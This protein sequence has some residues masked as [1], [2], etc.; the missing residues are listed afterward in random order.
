MATKKRVAIAPGRAKLVGT[1]GFVGTP[2]GVQVLKEKPGTVTWLDKAKGYYKEAI[3]VV[4][5]LVVLLN[6]LTPLF[7][8]NRYFTAA[9]VVVT[10]VG[11]L[12]KNNEQWVDSL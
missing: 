12:L 4:G 5:T 2:A 10:A 11:V 7:G 6:Q 9:A 3:A 1:V 8:G